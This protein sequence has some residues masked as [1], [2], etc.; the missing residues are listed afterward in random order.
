MEP[1]RASSGQNT[2]PGEILPTDQTL[3]ADGRPPAVAPGGAAAMTGPFRIG[4]FTAVRQLGAGGMGVVYLAYDEQLDRK[5]AIKVLQERRS[6][7]TGSLG[8]ARLLREAQA[9]AHVSHPNVAAVYE[10]GPIGEQVFVAMEF[11]EGKTLTQWLAAGPHDWRAVVEM[12]C[13]AGRGLAAAHA[14]E[15]VH[16]DFKPE[17]VIVGDDG[18][19]RVLDFGL[20]RASRDLP[21]VPPA[22]L[23]GHELRM[24]SSLSAQ[25]TQAGS[26]VGTPAYM[27]PEQY[28]RAAIDARSD[29]FS[30][31][32]SLFEG[33]Y[34]SRPFW[35]QTLSELMAAIARG[36]VRV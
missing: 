15:L 9:M 21:T 20:A 1:V 3:V 11:V 14:A 18:R 7:D 10:V 31:C 2:L 23:P 22:E 13:Q 16:R 4:R 24:S 26:L 19:A 33:L 28:V 36:K 27:S 30:F 29:Q 8:H 5:V 17:N 12:F 34:G 6:A 25:L 35:G 32:V